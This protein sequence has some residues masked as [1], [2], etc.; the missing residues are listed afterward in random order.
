[1]CMYARRR[2]QLTSS[3][4]TGVVSNG[5]GII[6]VHVRRYDTLLRLSFTTNCPDSL[7]K[8]A[9]ESEGEVQ[10]RCGSVVVVVVSKDR[11]GNLAKLQ[12]LPYATSSSTLPVDIDLDLIHHVHRYEDPAEARSCG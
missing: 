8:C 4:W 3:I 12:R 5:S 11:R 9:D 6:N 7:S 10:R 2:L 1:M